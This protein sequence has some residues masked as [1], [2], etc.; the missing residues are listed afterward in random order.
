MEGKRAGNFENLDHPSNNV[1]HDKSTRDIATNVV[2]AVTTAFRTSALLSENSVDK[3]S[4]NTSPTK[5]WVPFQCSICSRHRKWWEDIRSVFFLQLTHIWRS[6][7]HLHP[8]E[9]ISES[10]ELPAHGAAE[11]SLLQSNC[12][13]YCQN[14]LGWLTLPTWKL[15][16]NKQYTLTVSYQFCKSSWLSRIPLVWNQRHSFH[17]GAFGPYIDCYTEA[18]LQNEG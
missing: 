11:P 6:D 13:D 15:Q 2:A 7:L 4:W 5:I 16:N 12:L 3:A 17:W 10:G 9:F 18:I 8:N 1:Y 14:I